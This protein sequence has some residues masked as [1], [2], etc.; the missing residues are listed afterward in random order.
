MAGK[1]IAR[2]LS[3]EENEKYVLDLLSHTGELP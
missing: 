2:N 3:S 1:L